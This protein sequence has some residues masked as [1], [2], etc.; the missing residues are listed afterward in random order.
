VGGWSIFYARTSHKH[1]QTHKTHH[2]LDLGEAT[3]FPFI[4]FFVISH[5]GCIQ[6]SFCHGTPKLRIPKF[7]KL[8]F[9][10]LWRAIISCVDLRL[11]WGL[12]QSYNF[13]REIFNNIWHVAYKHAFKGDY[14]LLVGKSQIV[15]LTP[16]PSFSHNLCFKYWNGSCEP[17]LNIQVS[18]SFQ[19]YK[20]LFSSMSFDPW[21]IYLKIQNSIGIPT[22]KV[23]VHLGMCGFIPSHSRE[24]KCD[25]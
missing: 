21:N 19:W 3:T 5:R 10:T 13:H 20:E 2:D 24:C 6:M 22:P 4:L 15:I 16:N 25:S 11:R 14:W 8:G 17:I 9:L 12:K 23:G 1:T 7:P 18:R